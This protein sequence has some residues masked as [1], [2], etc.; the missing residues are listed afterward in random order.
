T[1]WRGIVRKSSSSRAAKL[2]SLVGPRRTDV[3]FASSAALLSRP[4]RLPCIERAFTFSLAFCLMAS[5]TNDAETERDAVV[6]LAADDHFAMPLAVTIRSALDR[7]APDSKLRIFVLDGGISDASKARVL[8]SLPDG[9]FELT[10]VDVDP[11]V[12]ALAPVSGHASRVN[13][14]RIL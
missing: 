10:W 3:A 12:L 4:P 7:L 9:R 8:A 2:P 14:Y 1:A 13:Y 11:T 6:V 5:V